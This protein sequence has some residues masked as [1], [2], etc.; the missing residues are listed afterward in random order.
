[1]SDLGEFSERELVGRPSGFISL[2]LPLRRTCLTPTTAPRAVTGARG[3][4]ESDDELQEA[5]L[6][7]RLQDEKGGG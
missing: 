1:M 7:K 6:D 3:A 5:E 2:L 4:E